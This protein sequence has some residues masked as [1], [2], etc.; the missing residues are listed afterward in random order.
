MNKRLL[1]FEIICFVI[2]LV[3][4]VIM[5][6]VYEW[7]H[8]NRIVAMVCPVNESVW[9]HLKL[10]FVPYFI[11]SFFIYYKFR[12]HYKHI[13]AG[14]ALGVTAGLLFVVCF[15]YTYTGVIG[16]H[17]LFMDLLSF[18]LGTLL[19]YIVSFKIIKKDETILISEQIG[20]ILFI[21]YLV[22][23]I[24]FTVTPPRIPLF[25]DPVTKSF[26]INRLS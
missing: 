23:F 7:S 5:H 26:G 18:F 9:E 4:G 17:C 8:Y 10:I 3:L 14:K 2:S 11:C 19:S 13:W 6:F 12:N 22:L 1:H 20:F 25:Q 24:L 21:C 16:K 15:Y